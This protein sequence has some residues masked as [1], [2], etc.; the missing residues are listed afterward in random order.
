MTQTQMVGHLVE[1]I[2]INKKQAKLPL[3]EL[4]ARAQKGRISSLSRLGHLSQTQT[5]SP[6]GAQIRRPASRSRFRPHPT[7]FTPAK[8]VKDSVL[9]VTAAAA[10]KKPAAKPKTVAVGATRKK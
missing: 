2:G 3:D 6:H 9:G 1:K 8:A 4:S 10:K 5:E 7:A